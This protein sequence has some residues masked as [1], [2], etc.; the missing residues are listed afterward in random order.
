MLISTVQQS[1]CVM[2]INTF[3]FK[4]FS[5]MVY[6]R[7]LNIV[8]ILY[9]RTLLFI[10]LMYSSLH[11]LIPNSVHPSSTQ[12]PFNS[13]KSFLYYHVLFC[14]SLFLAII[15]TSKYFKIIICLESKKNSFIM[16]DQRYRVFKYSLFIYMTGKQDYLK[17]IK[18]FLVDWLLAERQFYIL[19]SLTPELSIA[20]CI[21]KI[22]W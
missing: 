19:C 4:F 14:F 16:N 5:I 22:L 17:K 2:H 6:H 18:I 21:F 9:S 1:D 15:G 13:H 12:L 8:L 3:L 11:L 7:V 20:N 10:H